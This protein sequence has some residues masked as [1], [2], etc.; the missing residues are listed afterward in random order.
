[1]ITAAVRLP[2]T[3]S[4]AMIAA[5]QTFTQV[6]ID[7]STEASSGREPMTSTPAIAIGSATASIRP[8]AT[9]PRQAVNSTHHQASRR[10]RRATST[11]APTSSSVTS[12]TQTGP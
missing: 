3:S 11:S 2:A 4:A 5:G 9:G 6:A 1:M 7:S 8:I 12:T 10:L